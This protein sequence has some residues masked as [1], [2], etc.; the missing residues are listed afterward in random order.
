MATGLLTAQSQNS[1]TFQEV[2]VDFSHEEW[3]LL[4]PAQ[5]SLYRDVTLENFKNL[6]SVGYQVCK[7]SLTSKVEQGELRTEER[8]VLQSACAGWQAQLKSKDAIPMQNVPRDTSSGIRM[9]R[10][11]PGTKPVESN[12]CEKFFR[13]NL[14]FFYTRHFKEEKSCRYIEYGKVFR[15]SSAPRSHVKKAFSGESTLMKHLRILTGECAHECNQCGISLTLHPSFSAYGQIHAGEK[16]CKCTDYGK[17]SSFNVHKNIQTMEEGLGR[18]E[19]GKAFTGP[20]SLQKYVRTHTGEKFYECSDCGKVF[21]F[22]SSLKKHMRSHTG[23]KPYECN[24]CGKSFSQSSHLNVHRRTHT[25]EKPYQCKECGK[26]FTV[27]SSLQKHVRTHTG[28]K[29]YECSDC[30]KAFIDQSSLK[31]HTRSHTG[32]KPYKCNQC[33]K[34]FSTGSYLIVHKRTHTGEKTYECKECGKAF[35]NSSCLRVHVR[36]HTGEKPYKCIECGKAFSTSTNLIMHK[37][38]HTGQKV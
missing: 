37:R 29:P 16:L 20:V 23:E 35:R 28:E 33:G 24:H 27:P 10:T 5:K 19:C 2:A 25:G 7:H 8:E 9:V 31:K 17:T 12:H 15:H 13:K 30:G 14:H 22:Q 3:A 26:A 4:N 34:S 38:M 36:T 1:V 18:N 21:I 11:Q 6:A 32:E